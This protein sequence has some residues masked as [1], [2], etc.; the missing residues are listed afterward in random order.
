MDAN[1]VAALITPPTATRRLVEGLA[2]L[3]SAPFNEMPYVMECA[4]P[5]GQIIAP[6]ARNTVLPT[7]DYSHSLEYPFVVDELRFT[8][9]VAHT[10]R[11]WRVL[12]KDLSYNQDWMKNP[13][14]A[15]GLV[16]PNT[17][18]WILKRP[19]VI[20]PQGG[21]VQIYIDNLDTVNPITVNVSLVGVLAI[22]GGRADSQLA[23]FIR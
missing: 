18:S 6:N 7:Q 2:F 12:I 1:D 14:L 21:G 22:P 19:W 11:D 23:N 8:T 15:A 5:G 17:R 4:T 13:V 3:N 16:A 20:R 10:L 9:D